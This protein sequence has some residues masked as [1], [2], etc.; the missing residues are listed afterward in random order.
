[1]NEQEIVRMGLQN[2]IAGNAS[3]CLKRYQG[4]YN[5]PEEW[6]EEWL[7]SLS[8]FKGQDF[9]KGYFNYEMFVQEA[10]RSGD[11]SFVYDWGKCHVF[12]HR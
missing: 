9:L 7:E 1:M 3:E 4:Q 10:E 12:K 11:V 6:A 2:K 5:S 8:E